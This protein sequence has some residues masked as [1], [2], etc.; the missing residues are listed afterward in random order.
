MEDA[1]RKIL[2]F[3]DMKQSDHRGEMDEQVKLNQDFI[4]DTI[5]AYSG[6]ISLPTNIVKKTLKLQE[7]FLNEG[8]CQS[9]SN[10]FSALT[11]NHI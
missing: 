6:A 10:Y 3:K 7:Y 11:S 9:L 8:V 1:V 4:K 5:A 2:L